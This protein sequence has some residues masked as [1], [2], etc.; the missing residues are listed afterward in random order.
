MVKGH[1]KERRGHRTY[2]GKHKNQR[3]GG[4][5]G[6]RGN[7]GTCKHHWIRSIIRGDKMGR[8]G[9]RRP[10]SNDIPIINVGELDRMVGPEGK[11]ELHGIKILGGGKVTRSLTVCASAFS[12]SAKSKIETAGGEV[13]VL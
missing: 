8:H 1:T 11:V 13:V 2:H 7:A 3:G 4:S 9:F 5:R 10:V 12:G 6:G